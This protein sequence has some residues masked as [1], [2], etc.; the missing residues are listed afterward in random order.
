MPRATI[1]L[2]FAIML[3]GPAGE[4]AAGTSEAKLLFEQGVEHY[5]AA[6]FQEAVEKFRQANEKQPSWRIQYN[7]GQCEAVL[8]HYGRALDAFEAYLATGGD[9]V[10]T[11]RQEE[12]RQEIERLRDLSGEIFVKSPPG[13]QVFVDDA[14]RART[15]VIGGISAAVGLRSVRIELD[16]ETL[17]TEDVRVRGKTAVT[18]EVPQGGEEAAPPAAVVAPPLPASPADE[19]SSAVEPVGDATEEPAPDPLPQESANEAPP[20]V[21]A[22]WVMAGIGAAALIGGVITGGVAMSR[23]SDLEDRCPDKHCQDEGDRDLLD[24][25]DNLAVATDVLL[26]VGAAV[27]ATGVIMIVVGR[28]HETEAGPDPDAEVGFAPVVGPRSGGFAITG[29]F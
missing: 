12:V 13:A 5:N 25:V 19:P 23:Q 21:T 7:I 2:L 20:L 11:E 10:P 28:K 24:G 8:K 29:R 3:V 26:A 16:G 27:A 18:V 15:P 9:E 6:R 1:W 4:C 14:L 17:I 22:G